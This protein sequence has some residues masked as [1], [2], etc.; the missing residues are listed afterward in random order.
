MPSKNSNTFIKC[1]R[2]SGILI[3][4]IGVDCGLLNVVV[5]PDIPLTVGVEVVV[6]PVVPV[7]VLV[8]VVVPVVVAGVVEVVVVSVV[9]VELGET[10]VTTG[11]T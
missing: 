6:V 11:A 4:E 1:P 2:T 7:T 9:V 10:V 5:P 3:P 8:V